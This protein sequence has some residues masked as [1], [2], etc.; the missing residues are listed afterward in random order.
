LA[1]VRPAAVRDIL[2]LDG[3]NLLPGVENAN[4]GGVHD[5]NER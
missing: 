5:A 2:G 4:E 3:L 1:F